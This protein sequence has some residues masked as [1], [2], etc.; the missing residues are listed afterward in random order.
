MAEIKDKELQQI[1][2]KALTDSV[3]R[4]VWQKTDEES[5]KD[6]IS[7]HASGFFID[8]NLVV[9]N[10]HCIVDAPSAF[11]E[12]VSKKTEF[13][14]EGVVAFDVEN[15]LVVLTVKGEGVPLSL[16][17][18]D[19]VQIGDNVCTVGHP[20]AKKGEATQVTIQGIRKSGIRRFQIKEALDH[21]LSGSPLLNSMGE[22]IGVAVG[23][24]IEISVFSGGSKPY[25][26]HAIPANILNALLANIGKTEP[27]SEWQRNPLVQSYAKV[28]EGQVQI[29]Q[30]KHEEAMACFDA[31]LELNPDL[32][33]TYT[34]R[35]GVKILMGEAEDAIA[36]CDAAI[37]LNPNFVEAYIN[38]ASANLSLDQHDAAIADCD[39]V[40]KLNPDFVQAYV[41][42]ATAKFADE[43]DS[44]R[45]KAALAD[46]DT[47]L[48]LNP[49]AAEIYFARAHVRAVMGDYAGVIED[50]DKMI[51]LNPEPNPMFNVYGHRGDAKRLY[52]D[53]EGAIEDYDKVIQSNPQDDEAY[54]RRGGAKYDLGK[55]KSAKDDKTD[56][57]KYYQ[58]A[59]EDY[60]E[61]IN[62]R[63]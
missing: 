43:F 7:P 20:R 25:L 35:A 50:Y 31:A 14:I 23:A 37:K 63:Y 38:R 36:D 21:G 12:L 16:G 54:N 58:E 32:V 1:A 47:A 29:M 55:S 51:S 10:I 49:N 39:A 2:E 18:S 46:Y 28:R 6:L 33:E 40:L 44:D 42:R 52:R 61:A 56:A 26:G 9:T 53:Y 41:I 8:T 5:G 57:R 62:L 30:Q 24:V 4:V 19:T 60:S 11:V 22:V 59:I 17:N 27:L 13:P 34:N 45:H 48:K 15:D 3:V